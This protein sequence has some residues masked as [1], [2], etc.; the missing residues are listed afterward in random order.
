MNK[1]TTTSHTRAV[2]DC[3]PS[4]L[5][6]RTGRKS[7]CCGIP[8]RAMGKRQNTRRPKR[9]RGNLEDVKHKSAT[10]TAD[11]TTLT[12]SV[13]RWKRAFSSVRLERVCLDRAT[14]LPLRCCWPP[15]S[16]DR[17]RTPSV[18]TPRSAQLGRRRLLNVA[19]PRSEDPRTKLQRATAARHSRSRR[20]RCL[21]VG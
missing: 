10:T 18:G 12:T 4:R 16:P 17:A 20:E 8:E 15:K 3:G 2:V 1:Q 21:Y 13:G 14:Y 6:G 9:R 19:A 5:R 11:T 7:G